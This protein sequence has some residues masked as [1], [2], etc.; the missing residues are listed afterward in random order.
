[1]YAEKNGLKT[2]ALPF[3]VPEF[4][5]SLHWHE[6]TGDNSAQLWFCGFLRDTISRL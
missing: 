5:V 2:L 4:E 3:T 6:H 1:M